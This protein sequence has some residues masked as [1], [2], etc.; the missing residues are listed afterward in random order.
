MKYLGEHVSR[1]SQPPVPSVMGVLFAAAGFANISTLV[2]FDLLSDAF[3]CLPPL[4][5]GGGGGD[6]LS[7]YSFRAP[8][9]EKSWEALKYQISHIWYDPKPDE[10]NWKF[11]IIH[12]PS[13]CKS[14]KQDQS[15]LF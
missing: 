2:H 1:F 10:R 11:T 15:D 13:P 3:Y 9:I 7:I 6:R 4:I 5:S 14:P 12:K 8:L